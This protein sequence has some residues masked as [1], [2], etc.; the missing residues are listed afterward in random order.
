MAKFGRGGTHSSA[1]HQVGVFS[2][3]LLPS[4]VISLLRDDDGEQVV[5]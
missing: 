4:E 3:S 2:E 1:G 5:L